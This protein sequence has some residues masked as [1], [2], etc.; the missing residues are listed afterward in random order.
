MNR[1]QQ[2]TALEAAQGSGSKKA[3]SSEKQRKRETSAKEPAL[4]IS[5]VVPTQPP[6]TQASAC[7]PFIPWSWC[8]QWLFAS[9]RVASFHASLPV[10]N[11]FKAHLLL[12]YA[13]DQSLL[14]SIES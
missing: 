6:D 5:R 7:L 1:I 13:D 2:L 3:A 8:L 4:P 14:M 9:E 11:N 12:V 10:F